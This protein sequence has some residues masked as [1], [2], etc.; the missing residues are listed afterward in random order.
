MGSRL[1][2]PLFSPIANSSAALRDL[3]QG[4]KRSNSQVVQKA[5]VQNG[6]T[7]APLVIKSNDGRA[8]IVDG[9]SFSTSN[10]NVLKFE[11]G[12]KL[13]EDCKRANKADFQERIRRSHKL[14]E[15]PS[16][17]MKNGTMMNCSNVNM[18]DI[19]NIHNDS[20][21]MRADPSMEAA[22]RRA[23]AVREEREARLAMGRG[24]VEDLSAK[25]NSMKA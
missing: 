19:G 14:P 3:I 20:L 1:T 6:P 15:S 5:T 21:K 2:T 4:L 17:K 12:S 8:T 23:R 7:R 25:Y 22:N 24:T 18:E 11:K 13:I 16:L 9:Q 10:G